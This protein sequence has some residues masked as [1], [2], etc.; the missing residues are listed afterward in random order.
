[1][2]RAGDTLPEKFLV[3]WK[4]LLL[5]RKSLFLKYLPD[6]SCNIEQFLEYPHK[7]TLLKLSI[8][9]KVLISRITCEKSQALL[10]LGKIIAYLRKKKKGQFKNSNSSKILYFNKLSVSN[11]SSFW[12]NYYTFIKIFY[13][14]YNQIK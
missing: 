1:M 3:F 13:H 8:S 2:L 7:K 5:W 6:F 11:F 12:R 4:F 10:I 9:R 14:F